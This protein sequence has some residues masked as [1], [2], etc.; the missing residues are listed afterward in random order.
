MKMD[1]EKVKMDLERIKCAEL[2]RKTRVPEKLINTP[3]IFED[4]LKNY[5]KEENKEKLRARVKED[6]EFSFAGTEYKL[7]EDNILEEN[8]YDDYAPGTG[9]YG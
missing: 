1:L 9:N 5:V 7:N 6:N 2:L 3:A 4:C 8:Y